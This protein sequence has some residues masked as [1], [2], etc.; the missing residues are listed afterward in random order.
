LQK[1]NHQGI[2]IMLGLIGEVHKK[3]QMWSLKILLRFFG[4]GTQ[5]LEF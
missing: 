5:V 4:V 3:T 1:D 2:G